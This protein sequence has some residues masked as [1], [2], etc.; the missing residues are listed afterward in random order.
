MIKKIDISQLRPGM[1]VSGVE[2]TGSGSTS[3]FAN[4]I[5]VRREDIERLIDTGYSHVYVD[6]IERGAR[7]AAE[8]DPSLNYARAE[9]YATPIG[10]EAHEANGLTAEMSSI[11]SIDEDKGTF[12][13]GTPPAPQENKVPFS[14][15][16]KNARKVRDEAEKIVKEFMHS[17][18][19]GSAI[20]CKPVVETV[21]KMVES[22]FNNAD[23]LT[24]L[25]R[26]KSF[27][28]YTFTHSVNVSIM[29]ITL[30]RHMGLGKED[31][32]TLGTGA[33]L[34]DIGKMLVPEDLFK[35][36]RTLTLAEFQEIMK[37][38][39]LGAEIVA[40]TENIGKDAYRVALEHHEKYDGTGYP[41][42][43]KGS[44]IHLYAR[45]AGVA[46]TY[47][48]MTSRRIYHD[49]MAPES[50]LRR[51]F[52][53]RGRHYESEIVERLV[54][55][56]GIYPIGTFVELNTKEMAVVLRQNRGLPLKPVCVMV[57]QKDMA[58]FKT[59]FEID[60]SA[61]GDRWI[62]TSRDPALY[63]IDADRY[64]S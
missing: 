62:V 57:L 22:V 2:R 26:L 25:A 18:K 63:G 44:D 8:A 5:L 46:D 14:V 6:I 56:L 27:D 60:L 31:I 45:I 42:K 64:I 36:P 48:A 11:D 1:Y 21:E 12:A 13:S 7:A 16:V 10:H 4:N 34:H 23:A 55:C 52:L 47:D 50:A 61:S 30:A 49:G 58:P 59:R 19:M 41:N 39:H 40:K 53:L 28:N 37:H 24:S 38:A 35:K 29:C 33:M 32:R 20:E 54:S 43:L 15:E 9:A 17:V 3:F 51:I